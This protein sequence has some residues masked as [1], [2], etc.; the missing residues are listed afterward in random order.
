MYFVHKEKK[1]VGTITVGADDREAVVR[2]A[3]WAS[4]AGRVLTADGKPAAGAEVSFQFVDGLADEKVR[5]KLYHDRTR[6]TLRT[7]SSGRF[8]LE[9][10][11]PDLEVAVYANTAGLR[12]STSS[13]PII[14][15][16]GETADVG[17]LTLPSTRR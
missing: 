9:G 14:A 5:Q 17:D 2:M 1:L 7:D 12:V 10:M 8:R 13:R 4:I 6:S 16:S 15:K 11:F 3:P